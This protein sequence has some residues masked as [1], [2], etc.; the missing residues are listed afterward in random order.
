M[1]GRQRPQEYFV[2]ISSRPLLQVS[3]SL[4]KSHGPREAVFSQQDIRFYRLFRAQ[5]IDRKA[6]RHKRGPRQVYA[7]YAAALNRVG[8]V[9]HRY[10][11]GHYFPIPG[12]AF[13]RPR[14]HSFADCGTQRT[15]LWFL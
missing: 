10:E 15:W 3:K 9:D 8:I 4:N 2:E 14:L 7:H 12:G 1:L 13:H 6:E 11:I 5:L